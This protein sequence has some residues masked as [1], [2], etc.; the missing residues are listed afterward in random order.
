MARW[1]SDFGEE[2]ENEECARED[3]CQNMTWDDYE[4]YFRTNIRFHDLFE[5]L[6]KMPNFF[7]TFEDEFMAAENKFFIDNYHEVE[8]WD[9]EDEDEDE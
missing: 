9:D 5:H 4:E 2:F 6:K 8:D 7:E 3:V 1:E